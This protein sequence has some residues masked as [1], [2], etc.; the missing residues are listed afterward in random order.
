MGWPTRTQ[1]FVSSSSSIRFPDGAT[2][3]AATGTLAGSRFS[4]SQHVTLYGIKLLDDV[5]TATQLT[6][7]DT[8]DTTTIFQI[9][10]GGAT[11]RDRSR[12]EFVN[13]IVFPNAFGVTVADNATEILFEYTTSS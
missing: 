3:G 12:F 9:L 5:S 13:G 4:N 7:R 10:V 8:G 1:L 2:Y 11:G 6:F